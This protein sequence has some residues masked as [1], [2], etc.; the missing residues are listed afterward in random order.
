MPGRAY[1]I[2]P[3]LQRHEV[4]TPERP[5]MRSHGDR[6]YDKKQNKGPVTGALKA[7]HKGRNQITEAV[8]VKRLQNQGT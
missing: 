2:V 5:V 4:G 6:G 1:Y 7:S 3:T 8:E